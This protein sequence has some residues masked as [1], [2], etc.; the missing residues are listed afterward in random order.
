MTVGVGASLFDERFGLAG[1]KPEQLRPMEHFPHDEIDPTR[2]HGDLLLQLCADEPDACVHALRIL[3][4]ATRSTLGA[5]LD[6][7]RLPAPEHA[8]HG[9]HLD[10]QPARVQGRHREPRRVRT[11][12]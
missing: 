10:P 1:R 4:R 3:M 9:P 12:R 7:A 11:T 6:A 8:R 2:T 5:A